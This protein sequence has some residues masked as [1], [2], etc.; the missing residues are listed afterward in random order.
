MMV[1]VGGLSSP[2]FGIS[3]TTPARVNLRGVLLFP[4]PALKNN[5]SYRIVH[6]NYPQV[7]NCTSLNKD[8]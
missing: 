4:A 1:W 2:I 6:Q 8:T 7:L 5:C 3:T